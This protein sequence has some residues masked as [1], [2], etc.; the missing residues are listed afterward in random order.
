MRLLICCTNGELPP[1]AVAT[2]VATLVADDVIGVIDADAVVVGDVVD[3]VVICLCHGW[4]DRALSVHDVPHDVPHR[5]TSTAL[6][7]STAPSR[8]ISSF[9]PSQVNF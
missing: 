5:A 2:L 6:P 1:V 3:G 9:S 8:R 7:R 4:L